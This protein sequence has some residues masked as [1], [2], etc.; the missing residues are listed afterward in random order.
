M[1]GE[2]HLV[3]GDRTDRD[4]SERAI[5]TRPR[6]VIGVAIAGSSLTM[7]WLVLVLALPLGLIIV[8]VV[9]IGRARDGRGRAGPH[10][11]G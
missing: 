9:L 11:S 2:R 3:R 1:A 10:A 4:M 8:I 6:S 5:T 7:V